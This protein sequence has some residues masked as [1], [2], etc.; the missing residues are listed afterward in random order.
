MKDDTF[1]NIDLAKAEQRLELLTR[2]SDLLKEQKQITFCARLFN[3]EA[4]QQYKTNQNELTTIK[5]EL[6]KPT[7]SFTSL[8]G[9]F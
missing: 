8:D 9:S 4:R 2:Q 3:K 1:K 6:L 7:F 5:H